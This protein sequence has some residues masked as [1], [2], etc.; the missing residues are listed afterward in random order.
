MKMEAT[1]RLVN[2]DSII[3]NRF[4]PRLVFDDAALQELADSIKIH[5]VVEPLVLRRIGDKYEIIAGERRSKAAGLAGLTAVPAIIADLND[6]ES[7]EVAIIENTHR[8]DMSPIEEAKAYKKLLDRKYVTQDQLAK[9]LGTSQSNIANK[10]RLLNLDANVQEALL[11]DQISE[12]HARTL[13]RVTDKMKQ[14]DILNRIISEKLTVRQLESV[15][16]EVVGSYSQE[17]AGNGINIG[18]NDID[19]DDVLRNSIDIET[20]DSIPVYHYDP[21]KNASTEEKKKSLFFNNLEN[22]NVNMDASLE[23]G[24]NPF[25][26]PSLNNLIDNEEDFEMLEDTISEPT[27]EEKQVVVEKQIEY[28]TYEDVINGIKGIIGNAKLNGITLKM[29]EFEFDKIHQFIV[30][31]DK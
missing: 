28:E 31:V 20:D 24:F 2:L 27:V 16:D 15:V 3:P 1:I 17:I 22:E 12:R 13:L 5:G 19:V 4:Q 14:V 6:N 30:R 26:T 7:A 29:E 21:N 8:K 11:K 25:K 23:Y 9:R 18:R 10:M